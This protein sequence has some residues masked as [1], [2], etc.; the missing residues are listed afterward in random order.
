M[1]IVEAR[2]YWRLTH[3]MIVW[4]FKRLVYNLLH[5]STQDTSAVNVLK[6]DYSRHIFA[7]RTQHNNN[8][9]GLLKLGRCSPSV[10]NNWPASS[11]KMTSANPSIRSST[12][13]KGNAL[14]DSFPTVEKH[15]DSCF[16]LAARS[17]PFSMQAIDQ[18]PWCQHHAISFRHRLC[19][20]QTELRHNSLCTPGDEL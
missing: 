5:V 17:T 1:K 11:N 19:R 6:L 7:Y 13:Q 15:A 10:S 20:E 2:N 12:V 8:P 9:L 4:H 16:V 14:R 18:A 3:A